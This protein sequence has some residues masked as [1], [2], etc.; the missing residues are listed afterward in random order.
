MESQIILAQLRALIERAPDF[1]NY[2]PTSREQ[3][4]WLAQA[5]ALIEKWDRGEAIGFKSACDF[6][7]SSF[8]RDSSITKIFGTL[9]RAI[10]KLELL[11]PSNVDASF[12]AGDVYDFFKA[13][14][15]VIASAEKSIFIID[16]YLDSSVFDHYLTSRKS[17]TTVRLLLSHNAHTLAPSAQ[18]Y[19]A[20]NGT[21]LELSESKSLHDRIVFIDG[22]VCWIIGQSLKD[23]AKAKPTYLVQLPPDV[24]S[25]KLNHYESI[26]D[27]ATPLKFQDYD[28]KG[29]G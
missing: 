5:Y 12:G 15:R 26:W 6:M 21:V 18:K 3:M 9:Y 19:I 17:D 11:L 27:S 23:A 1:T 10:A 16:P 2:S 7:S 25:E 13:L 22:Y 24:V 28:N 4:I 29:N 14:N 20:Q 8:M